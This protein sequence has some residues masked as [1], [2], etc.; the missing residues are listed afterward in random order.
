MFE[1]HQSQQVL[2]PNRAKSAGGGRSNQR[3]IAGGSGGLSTGQFT[4]LEGTTYKLVVGGAG[5]DGGQG[6]V[7][8]DVSTADRGIS[9]GNIG[10][11][12]DGGGGSGRTGGG[13]GF[14]GLF[15]GSVSQDNAVIIAG[16]GGGGSI[17]PAL[18]SDGGGLTGG[19]AGNANPPEV[20]A[21][22]RGGRGG[23]QTAGG[24]GG[25]TGIN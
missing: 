7:G 18:G 4:F 25:G 1:K 9:S 20:E 11:G 14:T 16:G 2:H 22:G 15:V 12:G 21:E 23:T 13:G 10:G 5:E 6:G 8:L 17:D 19:R 24:T 3:S